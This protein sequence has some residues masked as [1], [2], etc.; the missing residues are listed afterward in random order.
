M[1]PDEIRERLGL[2]GPKPRA[3]IREFRA[4]DDLFDELAPA[5]VLIPLTERDGRMDV[6]LTKRSEKMRKHSGEVSFPGGRMEEDDDD[7]I[8]TA[9]RE[10]EE[11]IALRPTDVKVY[12]ALMQMP[13]VTGYEV[14]VYVGEF[15]QPYE[16]RPNPDEIATIIEAPLTD[17]VDDELH[18]QEEIEWG[19]RRFPMHYFDI[20]GH[21]VWGATAYMLV[22]LMDYLTGT[23][24]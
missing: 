10:S 11:E 20:Q 18:R 15:D 8:Q 9:L 4:I 22:E 12:G 24:R 21:N 13:T 16:L 5:A 7:L 1:K 17:F 19:G 3:R 2:L 6:V 14:S 23:K